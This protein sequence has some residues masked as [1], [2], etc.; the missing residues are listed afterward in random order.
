M[1]CQKHLEND[2]NWLVDTFRKHLSNRQ[3]W[4]EN[5]VAQTIPIPGSKRR[6]PPEADLENATKKYRPNLSFV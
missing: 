2:S 3:S 6:Q 4:P 1:E 5:D